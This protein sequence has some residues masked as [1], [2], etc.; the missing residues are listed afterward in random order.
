MAETLEKAGDFILDLA[1]IILVT[2]DS[3][4]ITDHV[5]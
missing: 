3:A 2:G 5:I 1:E 4:D